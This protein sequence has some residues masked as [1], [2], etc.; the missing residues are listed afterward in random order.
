MEQPT[1]IKLCECGCGQPAPI[2]KQSNSKRGYVKGQPHRFAAGHS[3]TRSVMLVEVGQRIGWGVVIDA[4]IRV[5]VDHRTMRPGARLRCDCGTEYDRTLRALVSTKAAR[6]SSLSC[7][8]RGRGRVVDRTGQRVGK[9]TVVGFAGIKEREGGSRADVLWLVKCDCGNERVVRAGNLGRTESCGCYRRKPKKNRPVGGAARDA[10]LK[11]YQRSARRRDHA[12]E[13]ADDD[14][15]RLTALDCYYCGAPPS[16]VQR[17]GKYNG[18]FT[19]NGLDRV[20]NALGYTPENVVTCCE[21][22]NRAKRDMSYDDFVRW[23]ARLTEYQWFHPD[24][25]PSHLLKGGV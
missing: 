18:E 23:I 9:I 13:L 12:W 17:S 16:T 8:C 25:M 19:Y 22:C 24:A 3:A 5:R 11:L 14:F 7:G 4:N 10:V 15:Y 6:L 2:A 20:D 21:T 1:G